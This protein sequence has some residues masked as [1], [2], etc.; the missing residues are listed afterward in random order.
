M[1][2]SEWSIYADLGITLYVR[3]LTCGTFVIIELQSSLLSGAVPCP[4][5]VSEATQQL[6]H[7]IILYYLP[8]VSVLVVRTVLS[9][10]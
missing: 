8:V 5:G 9:R 3:L 10:E 2:Q 7:V 4:G 1:T 6:C